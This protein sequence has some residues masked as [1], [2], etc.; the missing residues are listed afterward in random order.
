M[1]LI[2]SSQIKHPVFFCFPPYPESL[3]THSNRLWKEQEAI[4]S[5]CWNPF[6]GWHNYHSL[7]ISGW[8]HHWW[9][10]A[11]SG[12]CLRFF[13][14]GNPLTLSTR[15]APWRDSSR[16]NRIIWGLSESGNW[17]SI[18]AIAHTEKWCWRCS[19]LKMTTTDLQVFSLFESKRNS[20]Q[21]AAFWW[22]RLFTE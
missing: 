15:T 14:S 6:S 11:R 2:E 4:V 22:L 5:I 19:S 10:I 20:L 16:S 9:L 13:H 7:T 18:E 3:W 12:I 8:P 1:R 21:T 17:R